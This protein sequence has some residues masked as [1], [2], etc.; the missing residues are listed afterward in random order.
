M[1]TS[2]LGR[3]AMN[4]KY[5]IQQ[6]CELFIKHVPNLYQMQRI[7]IGAEGILHLQK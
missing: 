3:N 4:A 6:L 5:K 2:K 1:I 7:V